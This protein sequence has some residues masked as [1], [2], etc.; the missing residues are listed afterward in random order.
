M[1]SKY[2]QPVVSVCLS[3]SRLSGILLGLWC[4]WNLKEFTFILQPPLTLKW[5]RFKAQESFQKVPA[6]KARWRHHPGVTCLTSLLLFPALGLVSLIERG[7]HLCGGDTHPKSSHEKMGL[8]ASPSVH[9]ATSCF[10][11]ILCA[12]RSL[13]SDFAL[14]SIFPRGFPSVLALDP[15]FSLS[16]S[17]SPTNTWTSL[18]PWDVLVLPPISCRFT[19]S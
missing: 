4:N 5:N 17:W 14:T 6:A 1:V 2:P 19:K 18:F 7:T 9:N 3:G 10:Y 16:S 12:V 15:L 13:G 8:R 11:W